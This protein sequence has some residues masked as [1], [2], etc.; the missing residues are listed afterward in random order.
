MLPGLLSCSGSAPSARASAAVKYAGS[1][2]ICTSTAASAACALASSIGRHREQRLAAVAHLVA[3]Q[4]PFVLRDRDHAIGRGE[5]RAGDHRAHAGQRERRV[6][7]MRRI[8]PCAIGLRRMRP[9]SAGPERQ[10]GG[11]ARAAG[12]LFDAVDQRRAL[13][14]RMRGRRRSA[15]RCRLLDASCAR[16]A[17]VCAAAAPTRR[18]SRSRCSGTGCPPVR[19]GSARRWAAARDAA[20]PRRPSPCR[21]CRSRIA[22]RA[23][24]GRPAAGALMRPARAEQPSIVSIAGP[25]PR[26]Q[27]DAGEPRLVVDQHG[28]GAALAAVAALL[29]AGQQ[30]AIAQARRSATRGRPPPPRGSGR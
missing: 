8:T 17:S 5:V 15:R 3:R 2:S 27:R 25:A 10:V 14:D 13:A 6:A 20:A 1:G 12:D 19:R 4:R 22:C 16:P 21:A 23:S 24:R 11:V 29:G 9:T 7:S 18:S 30:Q 28:A 26:G